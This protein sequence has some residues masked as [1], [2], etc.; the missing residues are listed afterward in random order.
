MKRVLV[1][2]SVVFFAFLSIGV[3]FSE[4]TLDVVKKRG[5]VIAGVRYDSP[6]MGFV[7]KNNQVV[8][9]EVE[10]VKAIAEKLK[11]G[12]E[13]A[14]VT[15]KTRI[16][17][18]ANGNI[19][20]FAASANH[21]QKR[22]EVIDYSI[23]YFR[24]GERLL[25]RKDSPIKNWSDFEGKTLTFAQGSATKPM[26]EK[27]YKPKKTNYLTFQEKPQAVIAVKQGKADAY[28]SDEVGLMG[29]VKADPSLKVVGDYLYKSYFGIGVRENDSKWRDAINV[30][31]IELSQSGEFNKIYKKY[32][33][34]DVDFEIEE[35]AED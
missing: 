33:D 30:A 13:L 7:D 3:A 14:Q 15:A 25:V 26:F 1:L 9:F 6:P 22:D 10:L 8:G 5:K 19:D 17:M 28:G 4:S 18:L 35:W 32:F 31:I 11:V 23:T 24:T 21:T 2:A 12:V 34:R 20:M 29:L 16:P 27:I